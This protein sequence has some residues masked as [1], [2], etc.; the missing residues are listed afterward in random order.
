MPRPVAPRAPF[1]QSDP[2]TGIDQ[3]CGGCGAAKSMLHHVVV[4]GSGERRRV[5]QLRVESAHTP[6]VA[7]G[8]LFNANMRP[9]RTAALQQAISKHLVGFGKNVPSQI[10][11]RVEQGDLQRSPKECSCQSEIARSFLG[12]RK[13]HLRPS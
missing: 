6:V 5:A 9:M 4:V 11:Q 13:Q 3:S 12:A 7:A 8:E 10:E 1:K 2:S